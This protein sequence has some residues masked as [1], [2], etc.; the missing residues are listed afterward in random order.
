MSC[1]RWRA[2]AGAKVVVW[3]RGRVH[4][5]KLPHGGH[6]P[7]PIER[8]LLGVLPAARLVQR[9]LPDQWTTV[10]EPPPL[11]PT[12]RAQHD[13]HQLL[14][15]AAGLRVAVQKEGGRGWPCWA[16]AGRW[17]IVHTACYARWCR[18]PPRAPRQVV[19]PL[20]PPSSQKKKTI[21]MRYTNLNWRRGRGGGTGCCAVELVVVGS[22][23][24]CPSILCKQ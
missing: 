23:G 13:I 8:L 21:V 17:C 5:F 14:E 11:P 2:G 24:C 3:W 18:P 19:R 15:E 1:R 10:N 22:S 16:G 6:L 9:Y 12:H 7:V 4:V 20:P